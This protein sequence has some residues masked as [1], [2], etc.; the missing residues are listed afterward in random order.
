LARAREAAERERQVSICASGIGESIDSL[1]DLDLA[2]DDGIT[3]DEYRESLRAVVFDSIDTASEETEYPPLCADARK[4]AGR[5]LVAYSDA[6]GI[7]NDC[8]EDDNCETASIEPKLQQLW[9]RASDEV[10]DAQTALPS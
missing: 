5:A 2:L 4:A 8:V 7:W 9:Q 3:H 1:A 10:A 6:L